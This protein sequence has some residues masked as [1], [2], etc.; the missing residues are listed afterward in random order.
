LKLESPLKTIKSKQLNNGEAKPEKKLTKGWKA[1]WV[2]ILVIVLFGAFVVCGALWPGA[3]VIWFGLTAL[4]ALFGIQNAGEPMKWGERIGMFF[5]FLA[6]AAFYLFIPMLLTSPF[7]WTFLLLELA[8]YLP[9][10]LLFTV[11][12]LKENKMRNGDGLK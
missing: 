11:M 8:L 9:L 1:F 4:L 3:Y 7:F 5:A 6:L 12:I 2:T 10:G